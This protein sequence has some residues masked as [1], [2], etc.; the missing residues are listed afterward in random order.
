MGLTPGKPGW[1]A[2]GVTTKAAVEKRLKQEGELS[3]SLTKQEG[4]PRCSWL[5]VV[6]QAMNPLNRPSAYIIEVKR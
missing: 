3:P 6:K 1:P 5:L 2:A 4:A